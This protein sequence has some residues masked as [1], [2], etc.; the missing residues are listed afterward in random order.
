MSAMV[1][2]PARIR[3]L[4]ALRTV[5]SAG[6]TLHVSLVRR[7]RRRFG[8]AVELV[9]LYGP[10]EATMFQFYH[11]VDGSD[12][13]HAFIPIGR[14]LPGVEVRLVN[15]AGTPSVPGEPGP[16]FSVPLIF[17]AAAV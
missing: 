3:H 11:R 9:N 17:S 12:V 5:L 2:A 7:W 1:S 14:P 6:E 16:K 8:T 4:P 15:D 10:T 13:M